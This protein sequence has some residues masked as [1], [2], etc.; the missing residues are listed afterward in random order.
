MSSRRAL[1]DEKVPAETV[2]II[3]RVFQWSMTREKKENDKE[4]DIPEVR[5]NT[6]SYPASAVGIIS[7]GVDNG[8]PSSSVL[9]PSNSKPVGLMDIVFNFLCI[10]YFY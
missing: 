2:L 3:G 7:S 10:N 6:S 1:K 5:I 8:R 9:S 4:D